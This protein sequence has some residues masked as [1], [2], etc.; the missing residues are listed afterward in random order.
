[1]ALSQL[2]FTVTALTV[3]LTEGSRQISHSLVQQVPGQ[4]ANSLVLEEASMAPSYATQ[5]CSGMSPSVVLLEGDSRRYSPHSRDAEMHSD[6]RMELQSMQPSFAREVLELASQ[7]S[8]D[9]H[10]LREADEYDGD[11]GLPSKEGSACTVKRFVQYAYC[12]EFGGAW[13]RNWTALSFGGNGYDEWSDFV[14]SHLNVV[15]QLFDCFDPTPVPGVIMRNACIGGRSQRLREEGR[16]AF[17]DLDTE[18]SNSPDRSM[19]LK[20]DIE[21]SEFDVLRELA[22][23]SLRKVAYL[24]VEYHFMSETSTRCC[25]LG[26]VRDLFQRLANEFLVI[27]GAAMRWGKEADCEIEGGFEWPNAL[28]I[29]YVARDLI[30]KPV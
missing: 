7:Q 13:A 16:H 19:L 23:A 1:M 10:L 3:I 27:D 14:K 30:Q 11:A 17:L 15:P 5:A 12:E 9:L 18:L 20:L 29:S 2:L 25:D 21:G 26:A 8:G 24:T 28:S 6:L 22:D 4:L